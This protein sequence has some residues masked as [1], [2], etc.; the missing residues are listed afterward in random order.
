[1][2]CSGQG[3]R[4]LLCQCSE[5]KSTRSTPRLYPEV[6]GIIEALREARVPMAIASR[7]PSPNIATVFLGKLQLMSQYFVQQVGEAPCARL[8]LLASVV[9]V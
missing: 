3:K 7:T 4:V 6:R 8:W 2:C 5:V 1:M 9:L